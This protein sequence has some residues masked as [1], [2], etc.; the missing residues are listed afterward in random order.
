MR[1]PGVAVVLSFFIT[2][3]GQI[4]NGQIIKG[5]LCILIQALNAALMWVLIGFV[6]YPLFWI[7]GMYDAY[8]VASRRNV[9]WY[10]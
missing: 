4:Y 5:L 10:R 6:T 9:A 2:G 1:N 7:W 3:L 8:K